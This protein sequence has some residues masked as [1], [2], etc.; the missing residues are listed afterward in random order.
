M[1]TLHG[2]AVDPTS[3]PAG[4]WP[5]PNTTQYNDATV[6]DGDADWSLRKQ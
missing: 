5:K 6:K 1:I 3:F 2:E 4:T